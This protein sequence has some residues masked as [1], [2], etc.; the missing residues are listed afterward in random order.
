MAS[1]YS[2]LWKNSA[3]KELGRLENTARSRVLAA[4]SNLAADAYPAGMRKLHGTEHTFRLRVGEYRVVFSVD[5][6]SRAVTV[7]RVRHRREVYR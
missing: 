7:L 5:P 1:H 6:G 2:I 4:V 3:A